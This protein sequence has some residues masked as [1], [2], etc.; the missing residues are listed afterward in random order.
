VF[1]GD[2]IE[3]GGFNRMVLTNSIAKASLGE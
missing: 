3:R 1:V 2:A